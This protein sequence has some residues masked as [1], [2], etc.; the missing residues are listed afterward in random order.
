MIDIQGT[1]LS[2]EE[3]AWLVEPAVGGVILFTRNFADIDQ[4]QDLVSS[5]RSLRSPDLLIAVDQ[6]GGRVQRFKDPFTRLPAM[7]T[8]GHYY[9]EHP[10][11]ALEVARRLGWLLASELRAID[12]DL[13]FAPVVDVDRGLADVIGDRAL[14]ENA[15]VVADLARELAAGAKDAGMVIVAKH[16]PTHAGARA[17]SHTALAVDTRDY[18]AVLDD[19]VPY[20]RLIETGLHGIMAAHVSF[21]EI[22]PR[23]A[24]FSSWWLQEQLRG[25]FGFGGAIFSDDL[26]M[27]GAGVAEFCAD[28]AV[29][30]LDAGCDMVL[31][32][33]R[34]Q[35][36]PQTIERL[37][38]RLSPRSQ[39]HL[40]RLRGQH[41]E[42]WNAL[43]DSREW[44]EARDAVERLEVKPTLRLEG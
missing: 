20:R 44:R 3:R 38:D 40:V 17:D 13:S 28:R 29:L 43:R 4:L 11:R 22:D 19:L 31:L 5:I 33:N 37:N 7:R 8:L 25:E 6:E 32:C 27:A 10:Q 15:D 30:A 35:E 2:A 1:A 39:L 42:S 36:V 21:P 26:A 23:P 24:G 34:P 12:I 18:A 14:H 41:G 16:F 9:D